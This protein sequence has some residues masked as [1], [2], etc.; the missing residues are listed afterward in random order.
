MKTIR[1]LAQCLGA[2]A[3][4][5]STTSAFGIS[6]G[7]WGLGVGPGTLDNGTWGESFNTIAGSAGSV[8]TAG[9]LTQWSMGGFTSLG[10][11][12]AGPPNVYNTTYV[13]GVVTLGND[14]NTWGT[15]GTI[16][17]MTLYNTSTFTQVGNNNFLTFS[18][19]ATGN[20][21]GEVVNISGSFT[22]DD[23]NPG[24][25]NNYHYTPT[26]LTPGQGGTGFSS[27]R[28]D[29]VPDGGSTL[30]LLG[31]AMSTIGLLRRK[32]LA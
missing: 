29:V 25:L 30:L 10:A 15:G 3:M 8:I 21:G 31:A 22:G 32:L 12:P 4:V 23:E 14:V 16:T 24:G 19:T 13:N 5:V 9:D 26:G 28:I 27:L 6:T 1:I 18:F 17:G 11:T 7:S 20:Y 2:L